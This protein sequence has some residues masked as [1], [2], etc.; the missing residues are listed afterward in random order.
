[1]NGTSCINCKREV[2]ETLLRGIEINNYCL[3]A[4]PSYILLC[5][6]CTEEIAINLLTGKVPNLFELGKFLKNLKK[7]N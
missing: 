4:M 2:T 3:D 5:K 6:E 1:M 7:G